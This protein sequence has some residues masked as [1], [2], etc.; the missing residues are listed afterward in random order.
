[1]SGSDLCAQS[2]SAIG[3]RIAQR[4][5]SPVEVT[6]ATLQRIEQLEPQLNAFITVMADSALADA[7]QAEQEIARGEYRGPL[8]GVPLSLKDLFSTKGV[9]TTAAS[10]VFADVVP[11]RDATI[12]TRLRHAGAIIIG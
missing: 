3:R 6:E 10:R 12:V 8:H 4:E 2:L 1:V 11:D 9:R 7:R 5:V